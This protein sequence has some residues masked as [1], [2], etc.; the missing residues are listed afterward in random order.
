MITMLFSGV[1]VSERT[2][3]PVL[4]LREAEG[5]RFLPVWI[6]A[7]SANAIISALESDGDDHPGIHDLMIDALALLDAVVESVRI[8]AVDEGVFD[9]ELVVGEGTVPCRLSDGVALALRCGAAIL[10]D[11][12]LLAEAGLTPLG[13][14]TG[15]DLLGGPDEQLE[16][17]RAFLDTISPGDF[18]DPGSRGNPDPGIE[19]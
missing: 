3:S 1:R 7:A 14:E 4:I 19:G 15:E 9:A 12:D 2:D 10:A 11:E 6:T 5:S 13:V 17:F 8:T 16:R 18:D